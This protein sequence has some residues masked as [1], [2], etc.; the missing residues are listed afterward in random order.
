MEIWV[1]QHNLGSNNF[2][3][4]S[5]PIIQS[6]PLFL[7]VSSSDF[8]CKDLCFGHGELGEGGGCDHGGWAHQRYLK[9][10]H[11]FWSKFVSFSSLGFWSSLCFLH[12]S[13]KLCLQGP[14]FGLFP[15]IFPNPFSLWLASQWFT[16]LFLVAKGFASLPHL[17]Y[18]SHCF[19]SNWRENKLEG[20]QCQCWLAYL[21]VY[22]CVFKYT[23]SPLV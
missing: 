12:G 6:T 4:V 2:T 22:V 20:L 5:N 23:W 7:S 18:P 3:C 1:T 8:E 11:V 15:S 14:D 16:I 13:V 17:N 10:L 9:S 19:S 21:F